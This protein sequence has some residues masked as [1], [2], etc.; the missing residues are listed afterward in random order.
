M[1][2]RCPVGAR[3]ARSQLPGAINLDLS[4]LALGTL[5]PSNETLIWRAR[6]VL[7]QPA[8]LIAT[9]P[10]HYCGLGPLLEVIPNEVL[11]QSRL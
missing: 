7:D 1:F 3:A 2:T 8:L 9:A 5:D 11:K 10:S 4:S 6:E